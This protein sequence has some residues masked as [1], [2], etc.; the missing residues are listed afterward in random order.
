MPG[1][2]LNTTDLNTITEPSDSHAPYLHPGRGARFPTDWLPHRQHQRTSQG[3][4][5]RQDL[6]REIVRQMEAKIY[7]DRQMGA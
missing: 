7:F 4:P 5:D 2:K 6:W 1:K 3:E